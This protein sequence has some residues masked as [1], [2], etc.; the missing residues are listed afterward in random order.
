MILSAGKVV[1]RRF[2]VFDG[3][4]KLDDEFDLIIVF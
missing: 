1:V 3:D 2:D 4:P